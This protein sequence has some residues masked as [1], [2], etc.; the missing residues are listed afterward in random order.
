MIAFDHNARFPTPRRV[1]G[2]LTDHAGATE[3]AVAQRASD[4]LA[5]SAGLH[6]A[7]A[8]NGVTQRLTSGLHQCCHGIAFD[9]CFALRLRSWLS[10]SKQGAKPCLRQWAGG[11]H[12]RH[13]RRR[14]VHGALIVHKRHVRLLVLQLLVLVLQLRLLLEVALH[15]HVGARLQRTADG[16]IGSDA[17]DAAIIPWLPWQ[18][19]GL[20]MEHTWSSPLQCRLKKAL[21]PHS[22]SGAHTHLLIDCQHLLLLVLLL[23]FRGFCSGHSVR[24]RLQ[25]LGC[26]LFHDK[27]SLCQHALQ[28]ISAGGRRYQSVQSRVEHATLH[29]T[30]AN[31]ANPASL[32]NL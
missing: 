11:L 6:A 15:L 7:T 10:D 12:V 29:V 8:R 17:R 1:P 31:A 27:L 19:R 23:L 9:H 32:Q 22:T 4:R 21:S 20:L 25:L 5:S 28:C 3:S 30:T 26:R 16:R 13:R 2:C 14:G 18:T 24:L